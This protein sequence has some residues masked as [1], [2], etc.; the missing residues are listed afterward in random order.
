MLSNA[1]TV[2]HPEQL[3]H[4][5]PLSE[6]MAAIPLADHKSVIPLTEEGKVIPLANN[7]VLATPLARKSAP[8]SNISPINE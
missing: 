5:K 7:K 3:A 2:S 6:I 8:G 1:D 4:V